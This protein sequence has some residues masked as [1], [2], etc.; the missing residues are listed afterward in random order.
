[1][2][3]L[4]CI[5][6]ALVVAAA[7]VPDIRAA[8]SRRDQPATDTRLLVEQIHSKSDAKTLELQA[9]LDAFRLGVE[10]QHEFSQI[11]RFSD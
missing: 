1:M 7:F 3:T 2:I 11:D 9:R 8:W 4:V 6:A 10:L 5:V